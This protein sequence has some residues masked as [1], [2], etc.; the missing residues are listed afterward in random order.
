[1]ENLTWIESASDYLARDLA[2]KCAFNDFVKTNKEPFTKTLLE[3]I[4][5][6]E[7]NLD[8]LALE[9]SCSK[10]ELIQK[11]VNLRVSISDASSSEDKD[12]CGDFGGLHDIRQ[13]RITTFRELA[14]F[15]ESFPEVLMQI[16]ESLWD[17]ELKNL[18]LSMDQQ[19]IE[20]LND[21]AISLAQNARTQ[22]KTIEPE[23][24][25]SSEHTVFDQQNDLTIGKGADIWD[26]AKDSLQR[27][28]L[29]LEQAI[30]S[31][32]SPEEFAMGTLDNS[33]HQEVTT[34]RIPITPT[35][36]Q[37]FLN[38]VRKPINLAYNNRCEFRF[39]IFLENSENLGNTSYD[40][41]I[42]RASTK[43][44]V[45][46][47]ELSS[48]RPQDEFLISTRIHDEFEIHISQLGKVN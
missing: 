13:R 40:V 4:I 14:F 41:A 26:R 7:T 12:A 20:R 5:A 28:T 1:M 29:S 8:S 18:G 9:L 21:A 34:W 42:F 39:E 32:Q 22:S 36:D 30:Q 3:H 24:H 31:T 15:L 48:Q 35:E 25:M 46:R 37:V 47:F 44:Q 38:V 33:L 27:I 23:D 43:K 10:E 45:K 11:L 17:N 16:P 6:G 19:A 2:A